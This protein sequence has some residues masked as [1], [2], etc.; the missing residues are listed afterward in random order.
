VIGGMLLLIVVS[1]VVWARYLAWTSEDAYRR[2]VAPLREGRSAVLIDGAGYGLPLLLGLLA[3]AAPPVAGALTALAGALLVAG[4]AYA[5]ARLIR[6]A[7]R[8]RPIT[9]AIP[10][11]RRR[12]S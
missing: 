7:G 5:K 3:L 9:L 6:A 11:S 1:F 2:A 4:Q 12:S 10:L 8:L